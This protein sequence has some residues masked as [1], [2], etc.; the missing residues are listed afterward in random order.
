MLD[1]FCEGL[2][3]GGFLKLVQLFPEA[4]AM[5]FSGNTCPSGQ[6]IKEIL[7]PPT[8][9][10]SDEQTT[11]KYLERYLEECTDQGITRYLI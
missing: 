4:F 5:A 10:T 8:L 9:M 6:A 3:G 1:Q 11:F 2:E 7:V